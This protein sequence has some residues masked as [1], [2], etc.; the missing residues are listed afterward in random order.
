MGGTLMMGGTLGWVGHG[1][2]TDGQRVRLSLDP[3]VSPYLPLPPD[4]P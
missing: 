3:H 4:V 2:D 1:R